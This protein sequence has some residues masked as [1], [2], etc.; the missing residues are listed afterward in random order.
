MA[1]RFEHEDA[2]VEDGLRR[3]ADEQIGEAISEIEDDRIGLHETVHEVRKRCKKVRGLLRLVRPAFDSYQS[4]NAVFRD[5]ARALSFLRDSEALIETYDALV[6]NYAEQ[7]DRS[8]LASVRRRLTCRKN[9]ISQVAGLDQK[10]TEFRD[11]MAEARERAC[12][13][14]LTE[15]G[16]DAIAGGLAKTYKRARKTMEA[17]HKLRTP[18]AFHDYRK[19]VKYHWYHTCLLERV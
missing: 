13:W 8:A 6:E 18:E 17:A 7:I 5:A 14:Q 10:L 11:V 1:Y 4:E 3:I 2:S 19:R 9:E 12:T 15:D 16:F